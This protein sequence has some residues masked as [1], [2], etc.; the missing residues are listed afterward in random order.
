MKKKE[1]LSMRKLHATQKMIE[2][3]QQD[4]VQHKRVNYGY[5]SRTY[6][7]CQRYQYFRAIVEKGILKVAVFSRKH[8]AAG[9]YT[10]EFEI[11][12]SKEENKDLTYEPT[13]KKWRTGKIDY[14][15]Y[16]IDDGYCYG[17]KP[18]ASEDT[19]K[20]VND[21]LGYEGLEIKE[22]VLKF[23]NQVRT[24]RI[25]KKRKSEL[26]EI[27]AVMNAVPELP[28][29]FDKWIM[30]SAFIHERYLI[31]VHG[32]KEN[33]AFCTHCGKTVKLKE[34]P[35]HNTNGICPNCRSRGI[36]KS[37][38]KQKYLTD[39]KNVGII[40]KLTDKSGYILRRFRCRLKR[41]QEHGWKLEEA[42][43][44]EGQ[45]IKLN[46]RF[47]KIDFFEW[48]EY[49]NTG[50]I[51]WCHELNHGG[52][53]YGERADEC[54][55]YYRNL[56]HLRRDTDLKY[57]P[58]EEM[59]KHN[60]GAYCYVR[61]TMRNLLN[62][63]KTEY[64]LKAG[65][66]RLTWDL[67]AGMQSVRK[68]VVDWEQK[69][70][71]N[72]L[73]VTKEQLDMCRKMD[74]TARQLLVLQA[75]NEW[76]IR[77]TE[78]QVTFYTKEIGPDLVGEVFQYGRPEKFK[79]YL[80]GIRDKETRIADYMDYL[81]DV[82]F[83]C[84]D[85][86]KDILFP[87]NFAQTH[88]RL[89]LQ[90]QEKED[91]FKKMEISQKDAQLRQMI[92]EL[93]EIYEM[94]DEHFVMVLPECKEDFNREGRENH[95]CVGGI[96]FDKM[97]EGKSAVMFLRRKEKPEEAFCTVEMDRSKVLQCR[98]AFNGKAPEDA[99]QF[100]EIF[101]KQVKRRIQKKLKEQRIKI[102]VQI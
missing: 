87:K 17:N 8:L 89:A 102:A 4:P 43:C 91:E 71:W 42:G 83:L 28:K 13:V 99:E 59:W 2:L 88:Q 74:I 64:L 6:N 27:D 40:Q 78:D 24:D 62:T 51:R 72:A 56:K 49:R 70:P 21:Y 52:Y 65:L 86:T 82:R 16:D 60:Q 15:N 90:R 79:S 61:Q 77:L 25:K 96:Y 45:R 98:A 32:N 76:G 84:L 55:L 69:K 11:Y 36:F 37:W 68:D 14:L 19:K 80:E 35:K 53:Y 54:V 5:T 38:K 93:K 48:G 85:I 1:L 94:E 75:G 46:E 100:M 26:E 92:P 33:E 73:K 20:T 47:R 44:W 12:L 3:V 23:Q 31:Y 67:V 41:T 22:A 50:I 58:I 18:W 81:N 9:I 97:L 63:P 29:D 101:S 39:S 10:P 57:I 34:T 30:E 95:N 7:V 66:Y